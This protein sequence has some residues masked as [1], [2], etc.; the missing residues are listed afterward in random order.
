MNAISVEEE[1]EMSLKL[2]LY[3]KCILRPNKLAMYTVKKVAVVL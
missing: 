3:L 2:P 1:L